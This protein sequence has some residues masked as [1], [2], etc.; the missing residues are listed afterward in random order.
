MNC[1]KCGELLDDNAKFCTVCGAKQEETPSYEANLNPVHSHEESCAHEGHVVGSQKSVGFVEAFLLYFRRYADF[2]GRS[3][4]SEYW[5]ATLAISLLG[6]V[7]SA[8]VPDLAW[9]W[10][11]ATLVPGLAICVRRLHD[12]GKSGWNYLWI[13][14]PLVGPILLIIWFCKDS[15]EDNIWGPNPKT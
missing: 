12:I 6:S 2:K 8:I 15:T 9:I 4:R 14:L 11:L 1:R 3:R 5:W 10:S 13:L 7:I